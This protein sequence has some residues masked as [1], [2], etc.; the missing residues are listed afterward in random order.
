MSTRHHPPTL[1]QVLIMQS[2][3]FQIMQQTLVNMQA[4]QPQALPPSSR[5]RLGEF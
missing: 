3:M 4:A 1:E 2:Q 5:D